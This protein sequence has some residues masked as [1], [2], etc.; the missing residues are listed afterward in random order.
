MTPLKKQKTIMKTKNMLCAALSMT[1]ALV[2]TACTNND[3]I[4]ETPAAPQAEVKTIP[5]SVTVGQGGDATTRATVADD[6]SDATTYHKTLKFAAGDKLYIESYTRTD[7]KGILTL[8]DGDA[9]K[10]SGATF[11]GNISYTGD[12]PDNGVWLK[13][14]LVGTSNE[15]FDFDGDKVLGSKNP[16]AY[17]ADVKEAVEKYSYLS[18]M[19]P[20]DEKE[21]TLEQFMAFLN[22]EITFE[23]GTAAGTTLTTVVSNNGSPLCSADVKTM[24][25][26]GKVVAKFVLPVFEG[27]TL[28]GATVKM[29]DKPELTI[30]DA[31]LKGKVYN[32]KRTYAAAA[33]PT[34]YTLAE[35][36]VGMIVGSD[37]KAYAAADKN[38]LPSGVTAVAMVAYKSATAGSSLAIALADEGYMYWATA[39]STCQGKTAIGGYSWKLPSKDE[40]NQMFGADVNADNANYTNLNTALATAGGDSSKLPKGPY[41]WSSSE[42]F[43]DLAW[44][45]N[46]RGDGAYWDYCGKFSDQRVRAC[47]AF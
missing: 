10:T 18:D 2:M 28:S 21:F 43:E 5:Y 13:A 38:N 32:V 27:T 20:Y 22:F 9:G 3:N 46:L 29:G 12:A 6:P 30:N 11:E 14:T 23:D 45:V 16:S 24:T 41:Y 33:A 40:W 15:N 35:S 19:T 47:L 7:L 4:V 37:G 42:Y 25:E 31:E 17:Y 8:K 36:T 39:K 44:L 1:A 34:A 26:G